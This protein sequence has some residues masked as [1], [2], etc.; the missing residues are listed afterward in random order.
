MI[1]PPR[2]RAGARVALVAPAGPMQEDRI[3]RAL[4]RCRRLGLE[5]VLGVSARGRHGTYLAASDDARLDDIQGAFRDDAIDAVWALRGGY[6]TMRL[7]ARL[8]LSGVPARPKPYIGFSDNTAVHLALHARGVVSF[9]GPNAGSDETDITEAC[10][11]RVLFHGAAAGELPVP[12]DRPP[13]RLHGGAVD[14]PLI[15]GNQY[16]LEAM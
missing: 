4:Q 13:V 12:P 11:K 10:L 3:E 8:D 9:H 1:C 5:P 16:I 15:G 2:L 14:A 6:G 7:L